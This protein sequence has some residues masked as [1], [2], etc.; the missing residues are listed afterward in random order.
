MKKRTFASFLL[1]ISLTINLSAQQPVRIACVGN[2][3]TE[4]AAASDRT[5]KGY[6]GV[7]RE[8]MGEN[9]DVRNFGVSGATA[10][11]NTYKPYDQCDLF[12][13]AKEFQPNIVTIA[14]GTND[15]QPRVWNSGE[16]AEDF[17][18]D[19]IFLCNEF[20]ELASKPKIY[21]CLPIPIMPNDN[22]E[23]QPEVL[24]NE[25]IPKIR[26]VAEEKGYELIDLYTPMLEREDCYPEN[27]KLH[28]NDLGHKVIAEEIYKK[29]WIYE[30]FRL[31]SL[32]CF[33][34]ER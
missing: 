27:D 33:G 25:I 5:N 8:K 7:L 1:L 12:T 28:P 17:G 15:S 10:C 4:G 21:L 24:A 29:L 30:H 19:L 32:K 20:E 18:K 3:I 22:W 31:H 14:L 34:S 9:Y 6:V 2:S 16:F 26:K 11:R 23:H 13:Q